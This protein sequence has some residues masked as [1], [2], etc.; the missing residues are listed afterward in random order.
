MIVT[1][2]HQRYVA[3]LFRQPRPVS[4]LSIGARALKTQKAEGDSRSRDNPPLKRVHLI[5]NGHQFTRS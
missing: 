5:E 3:I 4:T 1:A 2:I